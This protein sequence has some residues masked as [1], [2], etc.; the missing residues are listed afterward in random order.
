VIQNFN[1]LWIVWWNFA[2]TAMLV[3]AGEINAPNCSS[4][5]PQGVR[6]AESS[7]DDAVV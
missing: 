5:K 2:R 6:N 3:K 1:A 4:P 7:E